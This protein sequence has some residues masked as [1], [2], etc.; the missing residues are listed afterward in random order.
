MNLKTDIDAGKAI[1]EDIPNDLRPGWAGLVLTRVNNYTKQIPDPIKGLLQIIDEQ[2]RWKEA[3][4]QFSKIREFLLTHKSFKPES[5]LLLA[6]NVAKVT[7]NAS[8]EAAPFDKDSGW[9]LPNCALDAANYFEG[10]TQENPIMDAIN[11][12]DKVRFKKYGIKSASDFSSFIN[13]DTILWTDWDPIGVNDLPAWDEY[14]DYAYEIFK[15]TK[16][17][18]GV[19]IITQQLSKFE[20]EHMGL[21]GKPDK[22]R[23]VA[24]KIL[25]S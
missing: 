24:E 13:I 20:T 2:G 4:A 25:N 9:W 8:G 5:Y 21:A 17:G 18:A 23:Q 14:R 10:N 11:I 12:F 15:L 22:C 1:F 19:D 6:E 3:H 7:Y 16:M